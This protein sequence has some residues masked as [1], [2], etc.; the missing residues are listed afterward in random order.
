MTVEPN[1]IAE[2][3]S[4]LRQAVH[5]VAYG[6]ATVRL[7][8]HAGKLVRIERILIDKKLPVEASKS[9]GREERAEDDR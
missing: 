3:W 5:Q 9:F 4:W 7:L 2:A 1:E 6:E 8:L